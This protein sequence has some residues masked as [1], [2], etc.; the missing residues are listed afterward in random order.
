M[1]YADAVIKGK[2][3][4]N[5]L[6]NSIKLLRKIAMRREDAIAIHLLGELYMMSGKPAEASLCAAEVC[7]CCGDK[8]MA[9]I[10]AKRAL[11]SS[12]KFTKRKAQDIISACQDR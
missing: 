12:S 8:R 3:T 7:S 10:H 4:G 5:H 9:L 2:L 1:I 6:A 11:S